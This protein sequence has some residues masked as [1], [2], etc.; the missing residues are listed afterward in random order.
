MSKSID[1]MVLSL[2]KDGWQIIV[3]TGT[4]LHYF[5]GHSKEV[6]LLKVVEWLLGDTP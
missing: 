4:D 5:Y 6:A 3:D 2:T 1:R